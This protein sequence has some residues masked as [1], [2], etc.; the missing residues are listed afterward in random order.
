MHKTKNNKFFRLW[1]YKI[2]IQLYNVFILSDVWLKVANYI[3]HSSN[4]RYPNWGAS[5]VEY[6]T[7]DGRLF[8]CRKSD[9]RRRVLRMSNIRHSTNGWSNVENPTSEEG[10]FECRIFDIR[11]C[12]RS[13]RKNPIQQIRRIELNLR[14]SIRQNAHV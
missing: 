13:N 8:E 2:K 10:Y 6:S 7:F 4:V 5:D 14:H 1:R 11:L 9:I 3:L 12:G